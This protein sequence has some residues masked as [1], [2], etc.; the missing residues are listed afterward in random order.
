MKISLTLFIAFMMLSTVIIAQTVDGLNAPV[1]VKRAYGEKLI[2]VLTKASL[3]DTVY[4]FWNRLSSPDSA[5]AISVSSSGFNAAAQ[6]FNCPQQITVSGASV[7]AFAISLPS[8]TCTLSIYNAGAD[9][10]PS[11]AALASTSIIV[12][13]S[14]NNGIEIFASFS[15]PVVVNG[16]YIIALENNTT[17]AVGAICTNYKTGDGLGQNYAKG[18]FV[19]TWY[20][21]SDFTVGGIPLNADFLIAP[22]VDFSMTDPSYLKSPNCLSGPNTTVG[23]ALTAPAIYSDVMYNYYASIGTPEQNFYWGHGD[24]TFEYAMSHN[25]LYATAALYNITLYYAFAGWTGVTADA[26]VTDVI[27]ICTSIEEAEDAGFRLYPNPCDDI[28]SLENASAGTVQLTDL[29]GRILREYKI[30]P[31]LSQLDV[32][33][34]TS[35]NYIFRFITDEG[36]FCRM[37]MLK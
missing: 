19:A 11:G 20:T 5:K 23:F 10:L 34:L 33:S 35:G 29:S 22:V 36:T 8:V 25:H 27:D 17:N 6:Y 1:P 30:L 28:L 14:F 7:A 26:Q 21:A 37:I 4:F 3:H 12:D 16:P 18:R 15:T 31:G 32:S 9:S 24:G 13:S 2:P